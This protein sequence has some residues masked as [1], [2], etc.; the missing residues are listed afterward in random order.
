VNRE[1]THPVH[2]VQYV[3][4]P[5]EKIIEKVIEK[6]YL[7]LWAKVVFGVQSAVILALVIKVIL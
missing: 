1:N 7:P 4:R 2:T 6:P 5:V 3:D